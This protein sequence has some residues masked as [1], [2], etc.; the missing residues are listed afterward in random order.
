MPR[1]PELWE[2]WTTGPH[3]AIV[4]NALKSWGPIM[5]VCRRATDEATALTL[6][7]TLIHNI[8]AIYPGVNAQTII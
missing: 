5:E 3:T 7:L 4:K 6:T 1:V 8:Q 2:R